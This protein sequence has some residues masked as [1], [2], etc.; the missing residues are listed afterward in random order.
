[1]RIVILAT[2]FAVTLFAAPVLSA[3]VL[4]S[5]DWARD[6]CTAWNNEPML[7]D[8]LVESGWVK[9]DQGRGFRVIQ[10]YRTDCGDQP[11]AEMRVS[12]KEGKAM[13]VYGGAP[14]TTKLEAESDYVMKATTVAWIEMGQDKYGPTAAMMVGQLRFDYGPKFEAVG[15]IGPILLLVGK[16]PSETRSCP[17]K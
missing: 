2:T 5:A 16:V 1:M 14:E 17:A 10:V 13:C 15:N 4:M 3:P 6:A 8:K 11:S 12:P 9:N 7:T